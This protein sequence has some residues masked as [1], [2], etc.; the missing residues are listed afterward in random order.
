MLVHQL[1]AL[2]TDDTV[3]Y[4]RNIFDACPF[5]IDFDGLCVELNSSAQE[6]EPSQ[7][8]IYTAKGGTLNLFYDS[9]TQQSSLLLPLVSE[10]LALRAFEL[11]EE[12]PSAFYG[13]M[14]FPYL[15]I[16]RGMVNPRR[17]IRAFINSLSD[18]LAA[19]NAQPLEFEYEVKVERD[20]Q[21]VPDADYYQSRMADVQL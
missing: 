16:K 19:D 11:R 12:A 17:H 8:F 5:E 7:E 14:Y 18:T 3:Q 21:Y 1:F 13:D 4:L 6:M 20:L 10:S 2:P 9:N 15:V